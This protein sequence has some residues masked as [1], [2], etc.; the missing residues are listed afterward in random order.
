LVISTGQPELKGDL[1]CKHVPDCGQNLKSRITFL[2]NETPGQ[3]ASASDKSSL[4]LPQV[5][6][7]D[8]VRARTGDG[9]IAAAEALRALEQTSHL[10]CHA[11]YLVGRL[12]L[13][14]QVPQPVVRAAREQA[15]LDICELFAFAAPAV[16]A[17]PTPSGLARALGLTPD[18]R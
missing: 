10:V 2:M 9:T 6:V 18:Q 15:H 4:A 7:L 13:V 11:G 5:M 16:M 3:N 17:V 1:G 14:A 12:S 8:G